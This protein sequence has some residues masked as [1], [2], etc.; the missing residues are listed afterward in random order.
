MKKLRIL[1]TNDDG[2]SVGLQA[3]ADAVSNQGHEV[4]IA[5]TANHSS[6]SSK[7]ISFRTKYKLVELF[8]RYSAVIV[9]ST[10]A[11]AVGVVLDSFDKSFD[12][13]LSGVNSGPNLGLW[14]VLS[15]GTVGAVLEA[16][17]RGFKGIAV[18]LVARAW[19]D[20]KNFDYDVYY[21]AAR[22]AVGILEK[23]SEAKW[24]APLLNVNVPAW[25]LRGVAVAILEQGMHTEVYTCHQDECD[26]SR[27]TLEQAYSCVTPGS[28][29]CLV[30]EGYATVTPLS[31]IS[32]VKTEWLTKILIG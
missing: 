3:L 13:I 28:D 27:W 23:L 6:G 4:F 15:S 25:T 11:T 14:D 12:F 22:V 29:V 32:T 9:D 18:S 5:T 21:R 7:S 24:E 30:K 10:P 19:S 20:Y 2:V 16:A 26:M 31:F 1:V 8:G 17:I